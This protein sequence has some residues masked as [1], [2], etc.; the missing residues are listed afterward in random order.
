MVNQEPEDQ[1]IEQVEAPAEVVRKSKEI[2]PC[3]DGGDD[4]DKA[5]EVIEWWF[6]HHPEEA[7]ARYAGRKGDNLKGFLSHE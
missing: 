4:G 5:I 1:P 3:P 6:T 7:Q 2:P